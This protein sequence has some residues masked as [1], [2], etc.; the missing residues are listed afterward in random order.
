ML[1]DI[2]VR[3]VRAYCARRTVEDRIDDAVAEIFLVA[4]RRIDTVPNDE[5]ALLWLYRVV[6]Q[7]VG[8]EWRTTARRR[9]LGARLGVLRRSPPP[10]PEDTLVGRDEIR[11]VLEAVAQLNPNDAEILR[12][13]AWERLSHAD[14]A[15]VLG[16][17]T[18]AVHQ[19]VHRARRN[20]TRQFGRESAIP[21][22]AP[23][24][25]KGG[26]R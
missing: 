9:R 17:T 23:A 4:W 3:P 20:L 5:E 14:I 2:Y 8:H 6:H 11:E 18:N 10:T 15:A 21:R 12:L 26:S 16:L 19:R 22:D 13:V 25:Q 24:T 1:Y 7:I